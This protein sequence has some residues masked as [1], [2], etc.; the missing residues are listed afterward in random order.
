MIGFASGRI[1]TVPTNLTLL[2][3]SSVVGVFWGRFTEEEPE[4][5]AENTSELFRLL[6]DGK[7]TP[8]VSE[9][10]PLEGAVEAL[11]AVATRRAKGKIIIKI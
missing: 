2:K 1:P 5:N 6:Q 10:Y 9:T 3:G 7:L 8:H 11:Q 4:T